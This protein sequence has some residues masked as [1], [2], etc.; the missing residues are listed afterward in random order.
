ME[1]NVLIG[2]VKDKNQFEV[3]LMENF[4]HIPEAVMPKNMLSV[5]YIALYVS[6]KTFGSNECIRYYGKIK[7]IK[8]IKRG[9]IT[10]LPT[11]NPEKLYYKFEVEEW[12]ELETPIIRDNGGIYAKAFTSFEKLLSG[13]KLSDLVNLEKTI[14]RKKRSEFTEKQ[15]KSIE[16]TEEPVGVKLL[17][18]RIN[19]AL[20]RE[21]IIPVQITKFLLKKG[22]LKI[23]IDGETLEENR[24]PSA[25]GEGIGIQNFWELNRFYREFSKNY[26]SEAAQKFIIANLN[27]I[28]KIPVGEA[29]KNE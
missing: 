3:N 9:E 4:Y 12:K 5:E 18:K 6:N 16:V 21:R 22:Y 10:T 2:T 24:V 19:T 27:E 26:Y 14:A 7:E 13:S 15:L 17:T 28:V 23:E 8:L 25:M 29:Y 1:N 11:R 20:G